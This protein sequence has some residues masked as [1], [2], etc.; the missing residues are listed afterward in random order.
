MG[1]GATIEVVAQITVKGGRLDVRPGMPEH[2]GHDMRLPD[3]RPLLARVLTALALSLCASPAA[4]QARVLG[5]QD[6]EKCH[7]PALKKWRIEEPALY[8]P[9]AHANTHKQL[10]DPKAAGYAKAIGLANPADPAGRCAGCHATVVRGLTRSGVSC[11]TCHGAGSGYLQVH[12]KEPY[13]DSYRKSLPLGLTD[14]HLKPAAIARLCVDC[15]VTPEKALAAAGHPNG[16]EFDIAAG[17]KKL[18]HWTPDF[19]P[20]NSPHATYDLAQVAAAA[21]PLIQKALAGGGGGVTRPPAAAPPKGAAPVPSSPGGSLSSGPAALPVA[22]PPGSLFDDNLPVLQCPPD[23]P[24]DAPAATAPA[25]P[26]ARRQPRSI[27][28]DAP[29]IPQASLEPAPVPAAP[30]VAAAARPRSATAD[31]AALRG[32]A[33]DG[34]ARLLAAGQRNP[35]LPAPSQPQ[36]FRG[37]D[38]ELLN[39]QDLALY[40][41]LEALRKPKE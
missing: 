9:K 15:H 5:A 34:L 39:I 16:A 37:P 25:G 10:L 18:V 36:E 26:P 6:C 38:G 11:E 4:A 29:S 3:A 40:L 12:D 27:V 41:A 19:T 33:A 31:A 24:S 21:R 30:A 23:C 35:S 17:L 32:R 14:L 28:V 20:D 13:A 2:S 7:K 22:P 8:G 1:Q